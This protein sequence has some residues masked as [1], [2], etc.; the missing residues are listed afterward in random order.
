MTAD[1][2]DGVNEWLE[3]PLSEGFVCIMLDATYVKVREC[4]RAVSRAVLIAGGI[5]FS[6]G[7]E[8]LGVQVLELMDGRPTDTA[9]CVGADQK[10]AKSARADQGS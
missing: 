1:L 10:I 2:M 3:R 9:K 7:G 6:G 8:V 4:G 5:R